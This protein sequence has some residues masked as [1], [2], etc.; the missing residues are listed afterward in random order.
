[1]LRTASYQEHTADI[2]DN[3]ILAWTLWVIGRSGLC[4]PDRALLIVRHAFRQLQG[5]I[6][7]VPIT[8]AMCV[9]RRYHRLNSDYAPLH[10]LCRFSLAH[11]G[12]T[13]HSEI[14]RCCR[15]WS[16]WRGC[17]SSSWLSG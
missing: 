4:R 14:T 13:T 16:I 12:P 3:Q 5:A 17:M 11:S 15:S 7:L 8:A 9:D 1:V 2:D 10:A 6:T